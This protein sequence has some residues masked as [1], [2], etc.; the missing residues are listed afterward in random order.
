MTNNWNEIFWYDIETGE[1]R[2][3]IGPGG[4]IRCGDAAGCKD[5]RGYWQVSYKRK[6][7]RI[8]RIVY[9]MFHGKI[10]EG[11]EIDHKNRM[12][13]NNQI[14][15]LRVATNSE[16]HRNISAT[17]R[18]TSGFVGVAWDK[19]RSKWVARVKVPGRNIHLGRFTSKPDACA[20]RLAGEKLHHGEFAQ[21][22]PGTMQ[23]G[24]R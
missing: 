1:L 8:H 19:S 12:K 2:W 15:N 7:Y 24:T 14:S 9:E 23:A 5:D 4:G 22:R 13:S 20:A 10:P 6:K 3:K 16:N 21:H 17:S 11:K 18:N